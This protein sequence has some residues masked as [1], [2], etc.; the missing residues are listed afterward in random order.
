MKNKLGAAEKMKSDELLEK[1]REITD[2]LEQK[3]WTVYEK[4]SG[5]LDCLLQAPS[6]LY[7][8]VIQKLS[9][10][11]KY[12]SDADNVYKEWAELRLGM[13]NKLELK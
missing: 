1:A 3:K 12:L 7:S 9:T 10:G 6:Y 5:L 8:D 13:H 4:Y 2:F 11:A